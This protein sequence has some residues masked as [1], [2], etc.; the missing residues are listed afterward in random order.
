MPTILASGVPV[1]VSAED[2]EWASQWKWYLTGKGRHKRAKR[3]VWEPAP[4]GR[5]RWL[6]LHREVWAR[7][8]GV[9]PPGFEI[10]HVDRDGYNNQRDNLRV[11]T[12]STNSV[13]RT[14]VKGYGWC[15][16][17]L[18]WKARITKDGRKVHLGYFHVE[19]EAAAAYEAAR[20][21]LYPELY[22]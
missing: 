16:R 22:D 21:R 7:M 15:G 6:N 11:V 14:G 5:K 3:W 20:R 13:N 10:D 9:I 17:A 19:A 4:V 1:Q 18:G 8:G 12:R 2:F